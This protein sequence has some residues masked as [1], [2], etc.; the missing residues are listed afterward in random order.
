MA[1]WDEI[2]SL[3]VQSPPTLEFSSADIVWSKVEGWRDNKDRVA[4]I[5]FARVD[6]FLRGESANKECPTRFHVEAR[7]RRQAKT[8]YKPKVDGV[9]EYILYWC[10]FG[11]D[12][13]RKG[14][15]VRPSRTT[16]LPKKKNAGRP[17]T[18]RGCTCHFIVKRLIAEPSVA[19]VIYNQDKHVDK[20]GAPCHGP[21]D[22]MA[23]GTRAMFAPYISEDLRLR[24][25]SLLYVGVSVETIMQRHN[26]SVEKQGGPSNRDDLLTHR[27]VRRQERIIRRS[28]YELDADDAVSISMW[29]E[30]HQSNVFY[31]EDFSDVDPFTLGIQTDWQL[32][33]MI[34]FGNRSLLASDSR[35]G[36]NKLK[37]SVHSLLVFNDDNKAIPVAWIVAPK[38]ESSNAHKWMRAL[39]NRVQTK[40]PAWKLAG[41]I[42]D[43]PL[44]DVLT[45]RDVFQCSVL[46][47]FW[48]VRH[49][50]HKNLVKKC[51]DNEMRA[52]ISR[53]FHQAMDNICQQRG[54]E[55]LFEDFI[56][57]FLDE[58]DFMD[59]FKATWYPRIGMWISAL[60][61]LPLASQE[62]CAAMEFYHNQLKLRLLNEK[63]PSVYT[64]VDWLVDKLGTKVHSYFW[65]DEYSEK[66]DFA[67]YWKDE[68]VSGLTSW[69]KALKIPD[70]NVV[71]EGTCAKVI[72]QLDQDKAYL[73]WN[74][75]SQFGICNCSWAEMG[76]LCEHVLKVISVC[77]KKSAMPSIS[78]LQYHQ[79]LIDML[80]CPPHDS[81]I[82]DHA[83]SLAVF[84]QN[85]LNGLVNL[86]SCNTTMDVTSFADQDRELVN[87]EVVSYNENNCGDEHVTAER[88]KGKL[89]TE[90][91]NQVACGNG[92]CNES[93]G[94]E[95]SCDEMDVD[96]SSICIS[97]PGL[98]SVDEVVSSSVF[99]GSRQRSLFNAETEDLAS[100]DDALTNTTGYEDDI[101]N[102]NRQ[103]NAM[104]EDIDIPSST[105][106]FVEQC[107]VTHPDDDHIHDIEPTVIC[108]T[109]DDNTVYNKISPSA[110][111][112]VESQVVEVAETSGVI[113]GNERMETEGKNGMEFAEQ[114]T[115]TDPNDLHCNDIEPTVRASNNNIVDSKTLPSASVPV[116][117]QV[118]E[119]SEAS[120][121]DRTE[122]ES[123]NGSTSNH[124]S[125]VDDAITID[126]VCDNLINGSD[127]SQYSNAVGTL[128]VVPGES[129]LKCS[130]TS[131]YNDERLPVENGDTETV[132][133]EKPSLITESHLTRTKLQN[134]A[135]SINS[136]NGV[137]SQPV[138]KGINTT[139][140]EGTTSMETAD[141]F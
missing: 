21:Q 41:F 76:N 50:W 29:V 111:I 60:Q 61:N 65:L 34:R 91:S 113:T 24:V 3:P 81:L 92:I 52:T 68:W 17:N 22:K 32:Q 57:D 119:V 135:E 55:G 77:R 19:L 101:L 99:S 25:L 134:G 31:Y 98:Y 90:Q 123:K 121:S 133:S 59:Y 39:Y 103:E 93:C 89:G 108:K 26:E 127:C 33:Q 137:I 4:L 12:D 72:N 125:S 42:V 97:P 43:D 9:L 85:Q 44:A 141:A 28:R 87:E 116:E 71:M 74:P 18:K 16:Y 96:P 94:E 8:P 63:K 105:M 117:S 2:L 110:S 129:L 112:P 132:S 75:G 35:F 49:A 122:I 102:R 130:S 115:V 114:C 37:Y 106:E 83:V 13:H 64:R 100:A 46:I 58:S 38:F 20:K 84:V 27:Y 80:H 124:Q 62:T 66:D 45:I 131:S 104:D 23:A 14:G 138:A 36:T 136:N 78:L 79:A 118:V 51:V 140:A 15:V 70:S 11:P 30:N 82:R 128:M 40:D 69:R 7:R 47:S 88:T 56:E 53:R 1:R 67:R 120:E 73:V 6:D 54:T 5:P 139:S 86:E 10:S 126:G 48:R 109:C 95:V 107:T